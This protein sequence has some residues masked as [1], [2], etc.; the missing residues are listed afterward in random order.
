MYEV[1]NVSER[2]YTTPITSAYD[3]LAHEV[4]DEEFAESTTGHFTALCGTE[5]RPR[6]A[7]EPVGRSC[8]ACFQELRDPRGLVSEPVY[9][10]VPEQNRGRARHRR[11]SRLQGLL[12]S[13]GRRVR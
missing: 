4:T 3:G 9:V 11:P 10:M 2:I 7:T 12:L 8:P 5:I 1:V 13:G 6:A